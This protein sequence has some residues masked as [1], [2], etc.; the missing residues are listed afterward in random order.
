MMEIVENKKTTVRK[1]LRVYNP[2][3]REYE[4]IHIAE[5]EYN[6]KEKFDDNAVKVDERT[7][8]KYHHGAIR[9][10]IEGRDTVPTLTAGDK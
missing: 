7:R 5:P 4:I 1:T 6:K 2:F 9:A 8:S 3:K 10:F